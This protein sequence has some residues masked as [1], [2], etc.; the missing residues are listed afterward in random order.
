MLPPSP[1]QISYHPE[2]SGACWDA[3]NKYY[4]MSKQALK[5]NYEQEKTGNNEKID[6]RGFYLNNSW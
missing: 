6:L 4:H 1:Q 5:S 3:V 2:K